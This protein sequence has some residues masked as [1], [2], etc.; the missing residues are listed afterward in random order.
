[1]SMMLNGTN[2]LKYFWVDVLSTAYITGS[3]M[4]GLFRLGQ[5][6]LSPFKSGARRTNL[7]V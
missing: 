3:K 2:I 4:D 7:D 6:H 5:F 1:M